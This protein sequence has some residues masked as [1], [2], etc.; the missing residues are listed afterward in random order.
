MDMPY[1]T[2]GTALASS[3]ICAAL[4][5]KL[6]AKSILTRGEVA[7]LLRNAK[8]GLSSGEA[9]PSGALD[10]ARLLDNIAD[11]YVTQCT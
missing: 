9:P 5:E 11:R 10:A 7:D 2:D 8:V 3:L 4:L 1:S 6:V